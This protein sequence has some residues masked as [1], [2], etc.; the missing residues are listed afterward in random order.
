MN[1]FDNF[2]GNWITQ[3]SIFILKHNIK[4]ISQ[5]KIKITTSEDFNDFYIHKL[6]STINNQ[7][8]YSNYTHLHFINNYF[9][10]QNCSLI[11]TYKI[12]RINQNLLKI[13]RNLKNDLTYTEYIYFINNNFNISISFMKKNNKYLATIFTSYIKINNKKTK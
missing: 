2:L 10:K 7:N 5:K 6:N 3:K 12:Q 11:N 1:F 4:H 8:D 9:N 13:Y